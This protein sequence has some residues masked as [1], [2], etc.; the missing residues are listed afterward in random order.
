MHVSLAIT[1]VKYAL[2]LGFMWRHLGTVLTIF[3]VF[4]ILNE[5]LFRDK[6]RGIEVAKKK[7]IDKPVSKS[8]R[9][10]IN[11]IVGGFAGE[12]LRRH[13][14]WAYS[15]RNARTGRRGVTVHTPNNSFGVG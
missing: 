12:F 3:I 5:V 9:M 13:D 14:R 15:C 1:R 6:K 11:G 7:G 4:T 10:V 2:A 8:A